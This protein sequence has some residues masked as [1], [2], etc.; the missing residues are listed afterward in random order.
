MEIG[1]KMVEPNYVGRTR[2]GKFTRRKSCAKCGI[3]HCWNSRR[4]LFK[5]RIFPIE[6]RRPQANQNF[7]HRIAAFGRR[8]GDLQLSAEHGEEIFC[9]TNKELERKVEVK[10]EQP[11]AS[12]FAQPK[13][14]INGTAPSRVIGYESKDEKRRRLQLVTTRKRGDVG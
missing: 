2:R 3:P 4:D 8:N 12:I 9:A 7:L 10:S 14:E 5:V 11:L 6:P 1:G 13:V